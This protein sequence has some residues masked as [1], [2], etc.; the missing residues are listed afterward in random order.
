[1]KTVQQD[2]DLSQSACNVNDALTM[3]WH[4]Q[5]QGRHVIFQD[6]PPGVVSSA[7]PH[8]MINDTNNITQNH[9]KRW[10]GVGGQILDEL[11]SGYLLNLQRVKNNTVLQN[12]HS[13]F[14]H[15][16]G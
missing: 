4:I 1:M 13:K 5:R 14:Q 12:M 6:I 9:S 10:G 16:L 3:A 11:L 7:K 8:T 2:R 15:L